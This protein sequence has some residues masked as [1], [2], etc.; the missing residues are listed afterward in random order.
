FSGGAAIALSVVCYPFVSPALRRICLPYV[1]ATRQQVANVL[2]ALRDSPNRGANLLDVGSGDGRIVLAAAKEGFKSVGVELNLWLVLYSRL[3]AYTRGV[4]A[5]ATFHRQDLWNFS[6]KPYRNVVI[7]GVGEMMPELEKKFSEELSN[8][9]V[10]VCRFPLPNK[11]P[12]QIIGSGID[13]VWV[14]D[15]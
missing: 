5:S 12:V 6:M 1:P 10:V 7:F 15:F 3:L 4:S 8:A 13:T 9:R 11:M 14:Y 2:A